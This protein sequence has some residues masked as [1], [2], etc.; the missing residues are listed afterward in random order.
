MNYLQNCHQ[1]FII[2]SEMLTYR[3][4][5]QLSIQELYIQRS[6]IYADVCMYYVALKSTIL[7][8]ITFQTIIFELLLEKWSTYLTYERTD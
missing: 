5:F 2:S 7:M 8:K 4:F 1:Y 6:V 3:L